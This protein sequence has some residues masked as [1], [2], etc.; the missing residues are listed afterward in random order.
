ML[1][2]FC[3]KQGLMLR[4]ILCANIQVAA[5]PKIVLLHASG[6][7]GF[8]HDIVSV[9]VVASI[10]AGAFAARATGVFAFSGAATAK[11][12]GFVQVSV[13]SWMIYL[14]GASHRINHLLTE[15]FEV[16]ERAGWWV[17]GRTKG[18][19]RRDPTMIAAPNKTG[20]G[21]GACGMGRG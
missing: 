4:G 5:C 3:G 18:W 2:P 7:G 12:E 15:S 19:A 14:S 6:R 10:V 1:A 16:G 21:G 8:F 9:F 11:Q 17:G 13:A 20:A